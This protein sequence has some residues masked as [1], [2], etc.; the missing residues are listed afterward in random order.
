MAA[1][2]NLKSTTSFVLP[3]AELTYEPDP[4]L[5]L[6]GDCRDAMAKNDIAARE[7]IGG[8][9]K[10]AKATQ[11]RLMKAYNHWQRCFEKVI[12]TKPQSD[13]G[14][15]AL[16]SYIIE[17][18]EWGGE[19]LICPKEWLTLM[20]TIEDY[21]S[22]DKEAK[23][24]VSPFISQNEG[25]ETIQTLIQKHRDL[26]RLANESGI[27]DE[28]TARRSD[29]AE[30]VYGKLIQAQPETTKD[31]VDLAN[32]VASYEDGFSETAATDVLRNIA[33]FFNSNRSD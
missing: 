12:S 15:S 32:Y 4:I 6:I 8:T 21:G 1:Q 9:S 24:K 19:H 10:E 22:E 13:L 26:V 25:A 3:A 28:E 18:S 31:A 23:E 30:L 33:N 5:D 17:V 2:A 29:A 20:R 27:G 16:A 11:R 14:L 7:E